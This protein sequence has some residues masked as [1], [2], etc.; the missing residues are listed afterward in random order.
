MNDC[1]CTFAGVYDPGNGRLGPPD[2]LKV[3]LCSPLCVTHP[4]TFAVFQALDRNWIRFWYTERLPKKIGHF[5]GWNCDDNYPEL[6]LVYIN[7]FIY[8]QKFKQIF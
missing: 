8:F 3:R 6:A 5:I 7:I 4:T 1:F 2:L